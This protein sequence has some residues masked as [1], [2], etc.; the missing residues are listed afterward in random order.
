MADLYNLSAFDTVSVTKIYKENEEYILDNGAS[1]DFV[2]VSIKDQHIS[3]GDMH[4]FL[5]T[6][7]GRWIYQGERL[8]TEDVSSLIN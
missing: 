7:Q 8:G 6:F 5:Q 3:R 1:A 2:T 4:L